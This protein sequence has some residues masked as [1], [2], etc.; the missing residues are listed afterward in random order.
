[1]TPQ[2][3]LHPLPN[4]C[5]C[6]RTFF[7]LRRPRTETKPRNGLGFEVLGLS[8]LGFEVLGLGG[9]GFGVSTPSESG[10]EVLGLGGLGFEVSTVRWIGFRSFATRF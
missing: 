5:T 4:T 3:C 7:E 8:E 6:F 10:F 2:T 9:S 1:M